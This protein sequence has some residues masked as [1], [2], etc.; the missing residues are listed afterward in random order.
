MY[1]KA[2]LECLSK[3]GLDPS[4]FQEEFDLYDTSMFKKKNDLGQT[5][6]ETCF[7]TYMIGD[8]T[9]TGDTHFS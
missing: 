4:K 5:M 8:R 9:E 2:K 7:E 6:D 1:E 3:L